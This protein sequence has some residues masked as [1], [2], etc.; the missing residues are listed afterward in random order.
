MID[1]EEV[2]SLR[3]SFSLGWRESDVSFIRDCR[4]LRGLEIFSWDVVDL[5]PVEEL[6]Q[7]E[8]LS[9][10]VD[11]KKNFDLSHFPTLKTLKLFWKPSVVNL[12]RC[13]DLDELNVVDYP[14]Q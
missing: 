5:T 3:L 6:E 8:F 11:L 13:T 2:D 12:E 9:I 7:L 4:N 10:Q 1:K 14:R